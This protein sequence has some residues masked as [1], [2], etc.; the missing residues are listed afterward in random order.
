MFHLTFAFPKNPV[1]AMVGLDIEIREDVL[2]DR[3]LLVG[4]QGLL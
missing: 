1:D 3:E 4:S 2:L